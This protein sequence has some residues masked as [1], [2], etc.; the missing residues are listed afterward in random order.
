MDIL[1]PVQYLCTRVKQS[2]CGDV[3]QLE[4]VLG[5]LRLM[6]GLKWWIGNE[7]FDKIDIY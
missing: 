5:Y 6:S 4:R 3:R 7:L 2:M 1:V